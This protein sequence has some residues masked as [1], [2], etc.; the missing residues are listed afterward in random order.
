MWAGA[1]VLVL[2]AFAWSSSDV[3]PP[4]HPS[5]P[6]TPAVVDPPINMAI[7][8]GAIAQY[9][10][11]QEQAAVASYLA[12]LPK[13]KPTPPPAAPKVVATPAAAPSTSGGS[14]WDA[15]AQCES[16]GNWA[17]PP[18]SGGFSGGIMFY[19]GTWHAYGGDAYAPAPYLASR[20]GQ[21][22]V[23]EKVLAAGGWGQWPGC[24]RKLG[25]R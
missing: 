14:V 25:L 22:A 23:A 1:A 12:S 7:I 21:I 2:T 18:V 19:I 16:G 10:A 20:E 5:D 17:Y 3:T 4:A 15:L 6:T 9:Q 8:D 13:P 24:S 11:D